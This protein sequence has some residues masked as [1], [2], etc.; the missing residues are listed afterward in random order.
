[1]HAAVDGR[2]PP[3]HTLG[4]VSVVTTKILRAVI[5]LGMRVPLLLLKRCMV[6]LIILIKTLSNFIKVP[7]ANWSAETKSDGLRFQRC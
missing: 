7:H 3:V 6:L 1:V 5:F 2:E 4:F